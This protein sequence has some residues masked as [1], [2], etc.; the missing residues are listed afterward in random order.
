MAAGL[1]SGVRSVL[2]AIATV[3]L[4]CLLIA[5]SATPSLAQKPDRLDAASAKVES[6]VGSGKPDAAM[7]LAKRLLREA[8]KSL[9][10]TNPRLVIFTAQLAD[11]FEQRGQLAEAETFAKEAAGLAGASVSDSDGF[12]SSLRKLARI[13][14]R[15][16][17]LDAAEALLTRALALA[18]ASKGPDTPQILELQQQLAEVYDQQGRKAEADNLRQRV[19][20]SSEAQVIAGN[21]VAAADGSNAEPPASVQEKP[22][23]NSPSSGGASQAEPTPAPPPAP[24][25]MATAP[26]PEIKAGAGKPKKKLVQPRIA[27]APAPE[28]GPVAAQEFDVVDVFYGT[29]R[30]SRT[31]AARVSYSS[32]DAGQLALGYARVTVPKIHQ[33]PQVERPW[34]V[35]VPGTEIEI[36][37]ESQD[38][39][40]HFTIASIE[41]LPQDEFLAKARQRLAQSK[42]FKGQAFVFVHG[43]YNTFDDGLYRTAQIA[44][45]MQFDGAAFMYSWPSAGTLDAYRTDLPRAKAAGQHLRAFLDLVAHKTGATR[46]SVIAH[47][48]GNQPLLQALDESIS[49]DRPSPD[50]AIDEVVLAAPD[51]GRAEFTAMVEHMS[52]VR[53]GI[54]LYAAS[55]DL[56]LALSQTLNHEPRAGDTRYGGPLLLP[57]MDT[58][59][60]TLTSLQLF[61]LNHY[62]V[63]ESSGILCDLEHLMRGGTR[64]PDVRSKMFMSVKDGQGTYYAY[65]P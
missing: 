46:I 5:N 13:L 9:P 34:A 57:H 48:M 62:Y 15:A 26:K 35:R 53:G 44:Y 59:D 18:E 3:A 61:R 52:H 2:S 4:V 7:A 45:D 28:A 19:S 63:A 64:P 31:N 16:K 20:T 36:T 25:P 24:P 27:A 40:K 14:A 49:L 11:L 10:K 56:A 47:S 43:F 22:D 39:R 12:I 41:A 65:R 30:Q 42:T 8:R 23:D 32:A 33:V 21:A 17:E 6:L 54:T 37:F 50:A 1:N 38:P 60:A 55:N 29:N 58:I 51:I